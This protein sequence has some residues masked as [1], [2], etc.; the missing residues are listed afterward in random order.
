VIAAFVIAAAGFALW[1]AARVEL[2]ESFSF[3]PQARKLVTTGIY[4]RFR[5]PVYLFG[6]V[7]YFGLAIAWGHWIGY[8]YVALVGVL[9]WLRGR[10][11]DKVLE[12]VF[13]EEWR[14]YRAR[15]WL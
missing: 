12:K 7:A 14:R 13:G 3:L 6:M 11:E 15:T 10:R 1:M 2:G 4:A 5:H 8:T 9:E